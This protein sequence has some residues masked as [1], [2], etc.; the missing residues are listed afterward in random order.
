MTDFVDI[1]VHSIPASR[2]TNALVCV[3]PG[4]AFSPPQKGLWFCCGIHPWNAADPDWNDT[5]CQVANLARSRKIAAI[6]ETGLDR[7]RRD[8]PFDAQIE[9]FRRHA[10]LS[11]AT[12]LPLVIHSV[13]SNADILSE[14]AKIS[15]RSLWLIHG[16][17]ANPAEIQKIASMGISISF[18]PRE[19]AHPD[20]RRRILSVPLER[21]FLETDDTHQPIEEVYQLAAQALGCDVPY[22]AAQIHENFQRLFGDW[23]SGA[24]PAGLRSPGSKPKPAS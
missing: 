17:S 16:C 11:E 8:I 20:A 19:L 5:F 9:S 2:N 24:A 1:H 6:G 21:L 12:S 3:A 10:T 4:F 23:L 7:F 15:P 13:R 14:F 22:L 18:G